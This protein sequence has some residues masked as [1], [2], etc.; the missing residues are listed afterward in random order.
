MYDLGIVVAR[1]LVGD[2]GV[3]G[4]MFSSNRADGNWKGNLG[5]LIIFSEVLSDSDVEKVEGYLAHKWGMTDELLYTQSALHPYKELVSDALVVNGWAISN[6]IWDTSVLSNGVVRGYGNAVCIRQNITTLPNEIYDINIVRTDTNEGLVIKLKTPTNVKWLSHEND[7]TNEV[8]IPYNTKTRFQV[9][10][11]DTPTYIEVD[12]VN[13]T[14]QITSISMIHKKIASGTIE[15]L[16]N[17]TIRKTA[18]M[19][20]W[21]V[22]TSSTEFINGQGEGYVQFQ[23][24]QSG[25]DI[26][27]G[28]T[29]ND[30]DYSNADPFEMLFSGTSIYIQ[31]MN[32]SNY[33]SGDWFRIKHESVNNQIAYLKRDSNLNYQPFYTDM[34]TT[35]GRHLYLDTSFYHLNGRVNDVSI[36]N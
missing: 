24:A 5:E 12:T 20:G 16:S 35:D 27:V 10:E 18:G 3:E 32:R 13:T 25:K 9:I 14:N 31:G 11:N 15:E 30:I 6:G 8:D 7:I 28:L 23:M 33:V 1:I 4:S 26:K 2:T 22:G 17:N 29:Y 36:V 19:D 21:N 34:E